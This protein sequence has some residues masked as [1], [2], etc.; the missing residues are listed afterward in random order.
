MVKVEIEKHLLENEEVLANVAIPEVTF[1]ATNKRLIR[2]AKRFLGERVDSLSYPHIA[3]VTFESKSYL[4]EGIATIIL[5]V[6][7]GLIPS[8]LR[9]FIDRAFWATQNP[10]NLLFPI[11][12]FIVIVLGVALCFYRTAWYQI[13]ATGLSKED[14]TLWRL[15]HVKE[16]QVRDFVRLLEQQTTRER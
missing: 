1:Y 3:S 12:G 14:L 7:V 16:P 13:R 4:P 9:G 2:H 6:I 10:A 8:I 11:L 5:G 15:T